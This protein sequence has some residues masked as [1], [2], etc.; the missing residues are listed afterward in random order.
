[1]R[2]ADERRFREVVAAQARGVDDRLELSA[3]GPLHTVDDTAR[4]EAGA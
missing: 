1:M 3:T 2:T 4:Q